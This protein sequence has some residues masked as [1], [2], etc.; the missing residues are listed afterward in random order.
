VLFLKRFAPVVALA[1]GWMGCGGSSED[2]PTSDEPSPLPT[3]GPWTPE[4]TP[5]AVLSTHL[6]LGLFTGV[7]NQWASQSGIPWD[8]Q[9]TYVTGGWPNFRPGGAYV[10]DFMNQSAA[11]G[12]VPVIE[13][14]QM[15][16]EPGG[17]EME[18]LSKAQNQQTMA[19]YF[20]DVKLLMQKA[21]TFAKPVLVLI[22]ADG[23]GFLE[24]QSNENPDAMAAV[25]STG[26]AELAGLPNTVAGWGL[27]F[28]QLRKAAGASN[29]VLGM[30]ISAWSSG[31]DISNSAG[32]EI[33][34][35]VTK[36]YQFHSALGLGSNITGDT[37]DVL[38]GD[39]SD[40]DANYYQLV[41]M[42]GGHWW[43]TEDTAPT[44]NPS[45]NRYA[46][47]LHLWNLA[48][49]KR[50]V[51]WQIPLGNS[52]HLDVANTGKPREGYKDNRVEFFLG[53]DYAKHDPL[54]TQ[55]GVVAL[56]FGAGRG[57]QSSYTNDIFTDGQPYLKSR[58][59]AY[60]KQGPVALP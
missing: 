8:A 11:A 1:L 51:L 34:A 26:L 20:A 5:P 24:Q 44:Y 2:T 23:F 4:G 17:K 43:L 28:L 32:L 14:Y 47:W 3:L 38:V 55:A 41:E 49:Q 27:A 18:F 35:A 36:G 13:L 40:R 48:S 46:Q 21:K 25:A 10:S 29:V 31:S 19:S 33:D 22:E 59:A 7:G 15:N 52:N 37:Y 58:A 50:W 53:P 16:D 56:Y 9:Y 12:F 54:F 57:D 6:S 30:H 60:Y 45:F 42:K 39:P